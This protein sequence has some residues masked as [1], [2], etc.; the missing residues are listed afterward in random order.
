MNTDEFLREMYRDAHSGWLSVWTLPDKLTRFFPILDLTA[1]VRYAESRFDTHDVYFG[2][3][4]RRK[5]QAENQRGG[6]E[7]VCVIPA[8]WS[9]IDILGP[10]HKETALPA[11]EADAITFLDG[12]PLRPTIVVSSGNGLHAYWLFTEPLSIAADAQ[13]KSAGDALRGWQGYINAAARERGWR[14]DNTSDLSRVLRVPGGINHK[15]DGAGN[16]VTV[17]AEDG[18]R[19]VLSDFTPYIGQCDEPPGEAA[20]FSGSTGGGE[21]ILEKC[22]FIRYCRDNAKSLTEPLWYAMISNLSLCSDG[23][24]LCRAFS[25]P[26]PGFD[27][28]QTEAK[29]RHAQE[30]RKPHTCAYI[31]DTLG[32]D[33][34]SCE[35]GCKSPVALAVITKAEIVA[36]LLD[37]EIADYETI[38]DAEYLDALSYAKA[39]LPA[40]YAKFKMRVRGKVSLTDLEKCVRG[41]G[42]KAGKVAGGAEELTLDGIDLGGAVTP[43]KWRITV[44]GG[45]CRAFNAKGADGEI[46][47]CPDPVVV[48]RRL[49]NIDDGKERLELSFRHDGRWK[50]VV[51]SRSQV[52]NKTGLIG[53]ADEGLHVTSGTAAELVNFLSDYETVNKYVIPRVSSISRLGWIDAGSPGGSGS[54]A[55]DAQFFPYSVNDEIMFEEDNGTAVLYRNLDERG[56]YGLWKAMMVKLRENPIARFITSASFASPLLCRIGVRTFVIHLWHMSA[57][58]KSAALKAAISVWGNPLRIMGNGFT[59]AVG[60]EQLAGTLRNLPFG[61]DEKQSADER[62]LSLEHL[63]YIL[64]QGSGKIRGARGGG[65]ADVAVWHNIVMLTG[66]E[67][68]TR[69]SSLDGIQTR[70][71]ELYGKPVDDTDFAKDVHIV[72]ENNY[73]FAGAAYMRAICGILR[74]NPDWLLREYR[75]ISEEFKARGLRNIHADYVSAVT[76]GDILAETIIFGMDAAAAREEALRCGETVYALNEAQM[77]MDVV[78][79]AW[80]FIVGWLVSNGNRFSP[81]ASPFYGKMEPSPGGKYDEFFVIPQY[82]DAALEDAGFNVKK[83]FQGLRERGLITTQTDADGK[84]RTKSSGSVGG[85]PIRGYLFR[86]KGDSIPPLNG[87]YRNSGK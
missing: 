24:A 65:N 12:L 17:I 33:C 52:Y 85:K 43:W 41:Y 54:P 22:A 64:G 75:S 40:E 84:E 47:A 39:N 30:E 37:A 79:R 19:Y 78:E 15:K 27:P 14:L 46:I 62:K 68:V 42:E 67:P 76:L 81:D 29:V 56:D 20:S 31:R 10:A 63:I 16:R 71:F 8:L 1:A 53:F 70:T 38:F 58:G 69:S 60:T 25:R 28:A 18:A 45:V 59:T 13:R 50:S 77:S 3:G 66:E 80:D 49:V 21:R 87:A 11:T 26:Y 82:L 83:T 55:G 2:V 72:S 74:E 9:D 57:S 61:I 7:D 48:T 86:L 51:G 35:A 4:L 23:P 34:G 36:G 44:D 6:N 73:G 32:F 5:K